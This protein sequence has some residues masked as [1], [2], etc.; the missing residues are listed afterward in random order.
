MPVRC[1]EIKQDIGH[2]I[3]SSL[4]SNLFT[5]GGSSTARKGCGDTKGFFRQNRFLEKAR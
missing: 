3:V 4:N 5:L 2:T 1:Q